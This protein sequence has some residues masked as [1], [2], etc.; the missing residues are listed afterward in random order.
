MESSRFFFVL[1]QLFFVEPCAMR[2]ASVCSGMVPVLDAHP[3]AVLSLVRKT[4][5]SVLHCISHAIEP[6]FECPRLF[7]SR[8]RVQSACGDEQGCEM[9]GCAH[10]AGCL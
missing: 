5:H 7:M 6:P 10:T 2:G 3:C 1:L 4:P 9:D 8:T